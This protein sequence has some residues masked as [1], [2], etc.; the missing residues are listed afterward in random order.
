[1]A[2]IDRIRSAN[3]DPIPCPKDSTT[4]IEGLYCVGGAICLYTMQG[5]QHAINFPTP[6]TL[7]RVLTYNN[8]AL[9]PLTARKFATVITTLNDADHADVAWMAAELALTYQ[10]KKD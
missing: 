4:D 3:P 5:T 9:D 7:S 10:P 8:A 2:L 1:M 6:D